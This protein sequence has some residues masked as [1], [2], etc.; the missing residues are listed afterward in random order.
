MEV[1]FWEVMWLALAFERLLTFGVRWRLGG[2]R[3][4][5]V[6]KSTR[7]VLVVTG[8]ACRRRVAVRS[9]HAL[10]NTPGNGVCLYGQHSTYC[11]VSNM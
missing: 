11:M 9:F 1:D 6:R 5:P 10:T 3:M 2:W 7:R 4:C 8:S